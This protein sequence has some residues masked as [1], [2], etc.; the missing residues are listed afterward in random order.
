MKQLREPVG[1]DVEHTQA[2]VLCT[3]QLI[4]LARDLSTTHGSLQMMLSASSA[5]EHPAASG[6]GFQVWAT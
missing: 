4:R 1:L 2:L 5:G 6:E 3:S